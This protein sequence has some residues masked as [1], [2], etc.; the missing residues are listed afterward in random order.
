MTAPKAKKRPKPKQTNQKDTAA[1]RRAVFI[2]VLLSNGE[3]ITD[4]A[5]AA[6]FSP[7]TAAQQGSRLLKHVE[8]QQALN[9]RRTEVLQKFQLT[10]D[11]TLQE[12]ARL[13]FSDVRKLFGPDGQLKPI[14][15]LDDDA[16]ACISS[17]DIDELRDGQNIIGVSKK[18]K[19]WDK[20]S[21]LE[22]A[23]KHL[24]AYERD[25]AQPNAAVAEQMA[26]ANKIDK[27]RAKFQQV[28]AK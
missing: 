23:M 27:L 15:E 18:F 4:A 24:G 6:G 28:T 17:I 14:H 3:N 8:V 26:E 12:I 22:K 25:N 11:R 19:H 21:A 20:N 16:A 5:L 2:E 10:T 1:A 13:A 7:K 9:S